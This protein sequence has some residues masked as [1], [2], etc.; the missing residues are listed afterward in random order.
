MNEE[1]KTCALRLLDK[2][3]VSRK[4][5]LDKLSEKGI[6]PEDAA[7]VADWLCDLGVINDARFAG[8]VVRHYAA[9]GYGKRRICE[10]LFRRGIDKELWDEA[11][12]ELPEEDDAPV[13][14]L[15]AKLRGEKPEGDALRRACAFLQRRGYSWEEI[16][17]AVEQVRQEG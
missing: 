9:K 5:L 2:R 16:S 6:T 17:R 7:E 11:L 10:E 12:E 1:A 13:R 3:D 15:R 4:M 14:L 8:L